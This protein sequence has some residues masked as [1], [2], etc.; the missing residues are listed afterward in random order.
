M[1]IVFFQVNTV[2]ENLVLYTVYGAVCSVLCLK[3]SMMSLKQRVAEW[4]FYMGVTLIV[5]APCDNSF[6]GTV[7]R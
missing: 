2:I 3:Q 4:F 7:C 1:G 6:G 5:G